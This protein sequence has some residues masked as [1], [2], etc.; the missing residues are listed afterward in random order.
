MVSLGQGEC[1]GLD[2]EGENTNLRTFNAKSKNANLILLVLNGNI[3]RMMKS[4]NNNII[5]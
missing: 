4:E 5:I 1:F 2:G 3:L